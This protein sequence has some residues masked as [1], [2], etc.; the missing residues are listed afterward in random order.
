VAK[1]S[2]AESVLVEQLWHEGA[3][4][5]PVVL[6][7]K[8]CLVFK[9]VSKSLLKLSPKLLCGGHSDGICAE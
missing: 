7:T 1:Y 2:K 6:V 5:L 4:C 8:S 3:L 9:N